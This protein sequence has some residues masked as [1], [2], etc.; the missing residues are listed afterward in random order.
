[1]G[2][3]DA[4]QSGNVPTDKYVMGG[5]VG[6]LLGAAPMSGLGVLIGLAMYLPF[7]ITLGY[8]VG[9]LT[10]MYIMK[11]KGSAFVEH[12]LVPLAAGLIVGEALLGI[13]HAA[14]EIF[15]GA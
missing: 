4:V 1:M 12:K 2:I 8:G 15:T 7:S 5:I 3:I 13:G 6:A 11:K 14:F 10:N 9:C